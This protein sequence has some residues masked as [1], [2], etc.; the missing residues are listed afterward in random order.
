VTLTLQPGSTVVTGA[1]MGGK[2]VTIRTL[3]LNATLA[4]W[5]ILP[6]ARH[7]RLPYFQAIFWV[8]EDLGGS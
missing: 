6:Y 2:S 1:N 5:G 4:G 8:A 7:F 3:V